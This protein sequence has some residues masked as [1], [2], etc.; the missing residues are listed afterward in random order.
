MTNGSMVSNCSQSVSTQSSIGLGSSLK[1][2]SLIGNHHP[3]ALRS[4][5]QT[6]NGS[7]TGTIIANSTVAN[8]SNKTS[9]NQNKKPRLVF[10]DL[11]R[12]TLQAIFKETKRPSKEMQITISQQ[13]GLELS[14]VGNFF[15]NARRRSQ[16]KWIEDNN[17]LSSSD[18][19]LSSTGNNNHHQSHHLNHHHTHHS[20]ISNNKKSSI[21]NN[22]SND[23]NTANT[24]SVTSNSNTSSNSSKTNSGE[25]VPTS[26]LTM[27][28]NV[29]VSCT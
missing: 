9:S 20:Q 14:T 1:H 2:A 8:N 7:G 21:Q 27:G 28:S 3:L 19:S 15:M 29:I 11:Q 13:L 4:P 24:T 25:A 26:V 23:N 17:P 18:N 5:N 22:N 16:D 10:T 6:L 12:R